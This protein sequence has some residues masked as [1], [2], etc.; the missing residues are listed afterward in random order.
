[1]SL[2]GE[3]ARIKMRNVVIQIHGI[4]NLSG[5]HENT[6]AKGGLDISDFYLP[7]W[8]YDSIKSGQVM[9]FAA[10]GALA[11]RKTDKSTGQF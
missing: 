5:S 9:W 3:P 2:S 4:D 11:Q 1:M 10:V 7:S 6:K 8:Q